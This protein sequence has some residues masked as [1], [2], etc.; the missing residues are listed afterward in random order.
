MP[1]PATGIICHMSNVRQYSSISDCTS[2]QAYPRATLS[3]DKSMKSCFTDSVALR[4]DC[5]NVHADLELHCLHMAFYP[6]CI[7]FISSH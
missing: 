3:I 6:A 5:A 1:L 4:S 2:M 7:R